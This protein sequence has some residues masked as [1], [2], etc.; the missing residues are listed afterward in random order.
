MGEAI[1]LTLKFYDVNQMDVPRLICR[2]M[3]AG[4]VRVR[5]EFGALRAC[6]AWEQKLLLILVTSRGDLIHHHFGW[7]GLGATVL[8]ATAG[9]PRPSAA[10]TDTYVMM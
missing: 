6:E 10:M 5:A 7:T 9:H 1:L 4:T 2:S 8:K 3:Q